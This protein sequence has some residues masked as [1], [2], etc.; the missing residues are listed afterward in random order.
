M[1]PLYKGWLHLQGIHSQHTPFWFSKC[2]CCVSFHICWICFNLIWIHVVCVFCAYSHFMN[3]SSRYCVFGKSQ[4]DWV[5]N[6]GANAL[7][8][9]KVWRA[10]IPTGQVRLS[11]VAPVTM[12]AGC[13]PVARIRSCAAPWQPLE[14]VAIKSLLSAPWVQGSGSAGCPT[15]TA[16]QLPGA[17]APEELPGAQPWHGAAVLPRQAGRCAGSGVPGSPAPCPA[18]FPAR[19]TGRRQAPCLATSLGKLGTWD[20]GQNILILKESVHGQ[21]NMCS[22]G[23]WISRLLL[24]LLSLRCAG[25]ASLSEFSDFHSGL[26]HQSKAVPGVHHHSLAHSTFSLTSSAE[27][28]YS[29]SSSSHCGKNYLYLKLCVT[30]GEFLSAATKTPPPFHLKILVP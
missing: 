28:P 10:E 4:T 1:R 12:P 22:A 5:R 24:E 17:L 9:K 11:E 20:L 30:L 6:S 21:I 25:S 29:I 8:T 27:N 16:C 26:A 19:W 7:S 18:G 15:P 23:R 14:W 2:T 13:F 3:F